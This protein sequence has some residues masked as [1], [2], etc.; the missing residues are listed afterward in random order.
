MAKKTIEFGKWNNMVIKWNVIKENDYELFVICS[1]T[2]EERQFD[3]SS[4][5]C[6]W[7]KSELR[8]YLN[9]DFYNKAFTENEKKIIINTKLNDVGDTKDNV[10]ILSEEEVTKYM[11]DDDYKRLHGK[12]CRYCSWT[13]TKDG[14]YIRNGW[15]NGCWCSKTPNNYYQIRPAMFL[16]KNGIV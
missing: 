15:A 5:V 3:S 7:S 2:I 10:F 1:D 4:N 16:K 8:K 14:C 12:S 13:R 6:D 9:N 11:G